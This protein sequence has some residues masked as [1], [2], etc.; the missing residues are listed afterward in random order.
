MHD[1]GLG[2]VPERPDHPTEVD[3]DRAH[4]KAGEGLERQRL[5]VD[6]DPSA[7]GLEDVVGVLLERGHQVLTDRLGGAASNPTDRCS[8]E[9]VD[10]PERV[11]TVTLVQLVEESL[12]DAPDGG[13]ETDALELFLVGRT[14][15]VQ[16]VQVDRGDRLPLLQRLNQSP[17]DVGR[18]T[19]NPR[20]VGDKV[21]A[22]PIARDD[23]RPRRVACSRL[24]LRR[25]EQPVQR[26][27][28]TVD[29]P[30]LAP[31]VSELRDHGGQF[32]QAL[33][34][35]DDSMPGDRA[36][37]IGKPVWILAVLPR[38]GVGQNTDRHR[39]RSGRFISRRHPAR[40]QAAPLRN[41]LR[42]LTSRPA[43]MACPLRGSARVAR[44]G[45]AHQHT[46]PQHHRQ[47]VATASREERKRDARDRDQL[48]DHRDVDDRVPEE[49]RGNAH[50]QQRSESV[51]RLRRQVHGPQ[52]QAHEQHQHHRGADEP[53]LFSEDREREV[54][55]RLGQE[56]QRILR[57]LRQTAAEESSIAHADHGLDR[58][59][60][61]GVGIQLR[62]EPHVDT[63]T[64]IVGHVTP[65]EH[66]REHTC[67]ED[68]ENRAT[69]HACR[70]HQRE[71]DQEQHDPRSQVWLTND[72]RS[73]DQHHC[74]GDE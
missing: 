37:Q 62:V 74:K 23:H 36:L 68:G 58:L 14:R 27:I 45:D 28:A 11:D 8:R 71:G 25:G 6:L 12:R 38:V 56:P 15:D 34:L 5:P 3:V 70:G 57:P 50:A 55:V 67:G 63:A 13:R 72:E 4:L 10:D 35:P 22:P 47:H 60:A 40:T 49:E 65:A 2:G 17:D 1:S 31:E 69:S 53:P 61:V 48:Q 33:R 39:H 43:A 24:L 64:L 21:D 41:P 19:S 30:V 16:G 59:V 51:A 20:L 52:G 73:R 44:S 29:D 9:H 42:G 26:P 7:R 18:L 46:E 66:H 32:V 54:G